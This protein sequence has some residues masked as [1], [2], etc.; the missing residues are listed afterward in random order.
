MLQQHIFL[1][2][3]V[4]RQ[5]RHVK[6]KN[7]WIEKSKLFYENTELASHCIDNSSLVMFRRMFS[8]TSMQMV[9]WT[10][11]VSYE[12]TCTFNTCQ[13]MK[14]AVFW[15]VALC[16]LVEVYWCFS[17]TCCLHSQG[18]SSWATNKEAA[19]FACCWLILWLWRWRQYIPLKYQ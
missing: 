14:H 4:L 10:F 11:S 8:T 18:R 6:L 7:D 19:S 12:N 9:F 17:K 16:S 15:D 2:K 1:A 3:F 13:N 5:S